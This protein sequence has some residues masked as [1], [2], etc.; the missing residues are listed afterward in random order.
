M[1]QTRTPDHLLGRMGG[2]RRFISLGVV[3]VGF[4]AGGMLGGAIGLRGA[5]TA[6]ALGQLLACA[7]LIASPV[8]HVRQVAAETPPNSAP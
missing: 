5:F 8:R 3:P 4:V 2:A 7:W 1:L 6:A